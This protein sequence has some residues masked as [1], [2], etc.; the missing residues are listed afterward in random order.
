MKLIIL[1]GFLGSGKTSVLIPLA[2]EIVAAEGGAEEGKAK[3]VIIENEIGQVGV[4]TAFTEG[5]GLYTTELFNGCVCCTIAASLMDSLCQLEEELHPEYVILETTGL[6]RP[7]DVAES[8]WDVYD[9]DMSITLVTVVDANRWMKIQKVAGSLVEEQIA[10]ANY[11]L[12]NKI[13]TATDE[14]I[15]SVEGQIRS[16][17]DGKVFKVSTTKDAEGTIKICKEIITEIESWE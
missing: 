4:D 11:V 7:Y 5:S 1:G 12:I 2:K 13:D 16:M 3:V 14:E 8:L 15:G 10:H 17:C 9:E 6:A